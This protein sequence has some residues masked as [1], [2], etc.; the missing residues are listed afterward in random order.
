MMAVI[1]KKVESDEMVLCIQKSQLRRI[2][3][4]DQIFFFHRTQIHSKCFTY[5]ALSYDTL[6][7]N[8][9]LSPL[10]V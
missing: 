7:S 1:L 4:A 2:L 10:T 8:L 9:S 3:F 6:L 5:L